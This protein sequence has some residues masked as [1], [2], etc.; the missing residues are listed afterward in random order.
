MST[1][2][3]NY[4]NLSMDYIEE[5]MSAEV[6]DEALASRFVTMCDCHDG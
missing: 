5:F 1:R 3:A 2:I 4:M 6:A